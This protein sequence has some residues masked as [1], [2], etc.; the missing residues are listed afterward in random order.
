MRRRASIGFAALGFS[1]GVLASLLFAWVLSPTVASAHFGCPAVAIGGTSS[2][3]TILGDGGNDASHDHADTITG[4]GGN[5]YIEGYSCADILS[6]GDGSDEIHGGFGNDNIT[7]GPGD[8]SGANGIFAGN[9][10]DTAHGDGGADDV[11]SG[12]NTADIDH[13]FGD[14]GDFDHVDSTDTDNSDDASGG[15]GTGDVCF[16]NNAGDTAGSGCETVIPS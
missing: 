15:G 7:G 4:I 9:G 5:D 10:N 14:N 12:S 8:D 11:T 2:G 16:I 13:L 6:G 1:L 3:E